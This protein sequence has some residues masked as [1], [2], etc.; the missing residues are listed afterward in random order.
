MALCPVQAQCP[1][2]NNYKPLEWLVAD[3]NSLLALSTPSAPET[4]VRADLGVYSDSME[5]L[6]DCLWL[7][8]SG[9]GKSMFGDNGMAF[10]HFQWWLSKHS[11]VTYDCAMDYD[12]SKEKTKEAILAGHSSWWTTYPKC[13]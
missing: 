3:S 2:L 10:G 9:R 12:C 8:E 6:L 4:S 11:N 1:Q 7:N 5:R 13:K